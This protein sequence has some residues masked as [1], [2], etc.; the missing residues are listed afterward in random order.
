M[1]EAGEALQANDD[2][3]IPLY[4]LCGWHI[5]SAPS[6]DT[7]C[8]ALRYLPSPGQPLETAPVTPNFAITRQSALD[9]IKVLQEGIDQ[10]QAYQLSQESKLN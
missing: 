2:G 5:K 4:P 9:L 8:F 7:I 3:I 10:C 1:S 6:L